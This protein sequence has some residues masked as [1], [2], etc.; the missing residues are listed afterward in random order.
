MKIEDYEEIFGHVKVRIIMGTTI[1]VSNVFVYLSTLSENNA[2]RLHPFFFFVC[3]S[4]I[5]SAFIGNVCCLLH[6]CS[7]IVSSL[8]F[9]KT[10]LFFYT[11]QY[12]MFFLFLNETAE[13]QYLK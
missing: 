12:N 9:I 3:V 6:P 11:F 2:S 7:N 8:D 10:E 1:D 4:L 5:H 13:T